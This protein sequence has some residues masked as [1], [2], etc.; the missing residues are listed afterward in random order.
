[1]KIINRFFQSGFNDWRDYYTVFSLPIVFGVPISVF[2]IPSGFAFF[3][4]F[5]TVLSLFFLA[6]L[7][8]CNYKGYIFFWL[9]YISWYLL[10]FG[11]TVTVE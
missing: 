7:D 9:V 4:W 2:F 5:S 11:M 8:A 10:W 6:Y 3:I 1:M